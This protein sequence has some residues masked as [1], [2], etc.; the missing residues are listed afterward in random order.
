[1]INHANLFML[2][3]SVLTVVVVVAV[4]GRFD[5]SLRVRRSVQAL[6]S[7]AMIDFV[8]AELLTLRNLLGLGDINL[9]FLAD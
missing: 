2:C 4:D 3:I 5:L 7:I 1:M 6:I 9:G 8:N